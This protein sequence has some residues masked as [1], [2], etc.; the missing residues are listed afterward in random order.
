MLGAAFFLSAETIRENVFQEAITAF[1]ARDYQTSLE[2]F[3]TLENEGIKNADLFYNIGNCFFRLDQRGPAILYYKKAM[4]LDSRHQAAKRNLEYVLSFTQDKLMT[5]EPDLL[6]ALWQKI[7]SSLSL[8]FLAVIIFIL[9]LGLILVINI[10]IWSYRGRD[11]SVPVFITTL[12]LVFMA[13]A[14]FFTSIKWQQYSAEDEGVLLAASAIGYSGPSED[15]TRVFTIHEGV[16]F[17]IERSEEEWSLIKLPNGLGGWIR[18]DA[19]ALVT[20]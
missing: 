6:S 11:K 17:E 15:Y 5:E 14:I 16:V 13:V 1:E 10:M 20:L 12:L 9:I 3:I 2:K 7:I 19:Y 4:K 18:K 8:D